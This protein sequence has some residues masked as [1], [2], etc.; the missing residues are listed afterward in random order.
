M[1]AS[2]GDPTPRSP[3]LFGCKIERVPG[4]AV[5]IVEADARDRTFGERVNESLGICLKFGADHDVRADG[6]ELRY[7][8][9]SICVRPPGCVWSAPATGPVGFVSID[10]GKELLPEGGV[11]GGMRFLEPERLPDLSRFVALARSGASALD[12]EVAIT[13]LVDAVIA[14]GA[15]SAAPPAAPPKTAAERAR[16]LLSSTLDAPPSLQELADA[17]GVNRFVLVRAFRRRFGLPP[18]AFHLKLRVERAR[19]LLASGRDVTEVAYEL[20]FADQSHFTRAF[21]RVMGVPPGA[22]RRSVCAV[23]RAPARRTTR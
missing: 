8:R 19:D 15:L 9:N 22:Y 7:P 23:P 14:A 21:K 20:G 1:V 2:S 12:K 3:A 10:I 18:H 4:F 16:E 17:V 6:K 11:W 13:E 5:E